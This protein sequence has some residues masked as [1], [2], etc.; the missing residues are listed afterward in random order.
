MPYLFWVF[1]IE[2]FAIWNVCVILFFHSHP[3]LRIAFMI[4]MSVS[5]NCLGCC[6]IVYVSLLNWLYFCWISLFPV[7]VCHSERTFKWF[8]KLLFKKLYSVWCVYESPCPVSVRALSF[9][10]LS[11]LYFF[12]NIE[13]WGAFY[14]IIHVC[15]VMWYLPFFCDVVISVI[16]Q[17]CL[18][19]CHCSFQ[20]PL[21]KY[22]S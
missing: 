15:I 4:I 7:S 6:F 16:W 17:Y 5:C 13:I 18:I 1:H 14:V 11:M 2:L 8:W 3:V 21:S 22:L 20:F 12:D 9:T 19:L 10:P